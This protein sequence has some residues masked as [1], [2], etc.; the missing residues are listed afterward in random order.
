MRTVVL[1]LLLIFM[2]APLAA[3]EYHAGVAK[4]VI[5]P[6]EYM[7]MAGYGARNKPAEGKAHELHAKA[8]AIQDANTTL[9]LV[10]T[11]LI[12]LTRD[13]SDAVYNG[14]A[15]ELKLKR[16]HV[17]FNSSHTHC[18]PVIREN[19][20]DMYDL[21]PKQRQQVLDY[22]DDLKRKLMQVMREAVKNLKPAELFHGVGEAS[23][24]MNRR[25]PTPKGIT[26]GKHPTGPVDHSVPVLK[27][28]VG[29]KPLAA[30]F[31]YACHN[32]TLSYYQWCGDYAGF[33]Q[34]EFE[35]TNPGVMALYWIGCGGDSNPQ[36]RGTEELAIKHGKELAAGV[37]A[38]LAKPMKA[39]QGKLA[40]AYGTVVLTFASTPTRAQLQ[41]DALSKTFAV[42][43]RAE[44][45]LKLL[46]IGQEV[47]KTYDH[48]PVQTWAIGGDVTMIGLGG[49]VV[50]DYAIRIRK[51][52]GN[53]RALW[54]AGYCNDV[55]AYVA[56][57]RVIGEGGYEADSSMIYYGMPSKWADS[58]EEIIIAE[59]KRQ[60]TQ[61]RK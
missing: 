51:E 61:L 57:K 8:L 52:L 49:E 58:V 39:V 9:V 27:V 32:T 29:G 40:A 45:F 16:E 14:V 30:V 4:I 26:N 7:W 24:A 19:L 21:S 35:K 15:K 37:N 20:N 2:L 43:T 47:P 50:I 44:R 36:P 53:Q 56:S 34:D 12:G 31:G 41:A 11:D 18:G 6:K 33:A 59:V 42:K 38:V 3:A 1:S 28:V 60:T 5:T 54:I 48:Y 23:F 46:D 17:L 22:T 25:E 13:V 55:M 10:T